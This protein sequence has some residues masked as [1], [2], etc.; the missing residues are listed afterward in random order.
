VIRF[1]PG[2]EPVEDLAPANWVREAF[3]D[4]PARQHFI[5]SDLVPPVFE[6]YP[7][8]LY[9]S[10]RPSDGRIPTGSWAERAAE[11][12][13]ELGPTTN[14]DEMTGPNSDEGQRDDWRPGEGS[15][16]E[17][18]METLALF[19]SGHTTTLFVCWFAMWSGW[20]E[21]S[22]GSSTLY[23]SRGGTIAEL[24]IRWRNRLESWKA[25]REAARLKTFPLLGQSGR[26]YLL[27]MEPSTKQRDSISAIDSSRRHSG[28]QTIEPG[29]STPRS[30][31]PVPFLG[32]SREMVDFLVREQILESFEVGEDSLA[33]L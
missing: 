10:Y 24:K 19:L 30:T 29:S 20:G 15:L 1:P 7:R 32:G 31:P 18:E 3:R 25:R 28:G 9:R 17:Q 14:W 11:L 22:G 26:S 6:A 21:L 16:I 33:A 5:V 8:V 23:R 4:W 12:G 2:L 27:L 13:R